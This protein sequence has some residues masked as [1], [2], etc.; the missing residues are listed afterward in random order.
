MKLLE[1]QAHFEDYWFNKGPQEGMRILDNGFL[2]YFT[3]AWCK[4]CQKL[5]LARLEL[6][7]TAR[8][9]TLLKCDETINDYTAG[10]CQVRAF[11]TFV[12][13]TPGKEVSRI[14]SSITEDVESWINML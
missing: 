8:G 13:F 2:V 10:Y 6:A 3:A 4:P 11:P 12:F 9:L 5:D 14:K 1:T 7:A